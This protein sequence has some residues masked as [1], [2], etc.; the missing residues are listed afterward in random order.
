MI[1]TAV[2]VSEERDRTDRALD[3]FAVDAAVVKEAREAFPARERVADRLGEL[4]LLA[5]QA[6]L[7]VKPGFRMATTVRLFS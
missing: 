6:E 2:R 3:G 4:C 1:G 5:D 7:F